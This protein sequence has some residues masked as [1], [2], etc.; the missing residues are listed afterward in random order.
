MVGEKFF[1]SISSLTDSELVSC[2]RFAK[3]DFFNKRVAISKTISLFKKDKTTFLL[4]L[5]NEQKIFKKIFGS[6]DKFST[7]TLT[8]HFH[9]CLLLIED[10][11]VYTQTQRNKDGQ[12]KILENFYNERGSKKE[13]ETINAKRIKLTSNKNINFATYLKLYNLYIKKFDIM[14][15]RFDNETFENIQIALDN[16]DKFYFLAKMHWSQ[17][18]EALNS[19]SNFDYDKRCLEEIRNLVTNDEDLA[20][21]TLFRIYLETYKLYN[22]NFSETAYFEFKELITSNLEQFDSSSKK[23]FLTDLYNYVS[24]LYSAESVKKWIEESFEILKLQIKHK[25]LIEKNQFPEVNFSQGI[26]VAISLGEYQWA[27]NF[28]EE[29]SCFIDN[30]TLLQKS[31][32]EVFY[33]LKQYEKASDLIQEMSLSTFADNFEMKTLYAKILF[34][35]KAYDVLGGHLHSYDLYLRRYKDAS[36][37]LIDRN[38]RF[39]QYVGRLFRNKNNPKKIEK[40]H[41][42]IQEDKLVFNKSWLISKTETIIN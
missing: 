22:G 1:Y 30:G 28:I 8:E 13:A 14:V 19:V 4:L 23:H 2:V 39:V 31:R 6:K 33:N 17:E 3:H 9:Y 24:Y 42:D 25:T 32:A 37:D 29:F 21:K 18:L 5:E 41:L 26:R 20:K 40:L 12:L 34:D 10:F 27:E 11:I 7:K 36:E 38:L 16:L 15:T 35:Q